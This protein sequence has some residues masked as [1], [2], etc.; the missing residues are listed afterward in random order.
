[1]AATEK[2]K[3]WALKASRFLRA[4]LKRAGLTYQHLADRLTEHGLPETEGS[5]AAKI[6]RG[7]FPVAFWLACLAVL[8][9]GATT[10]EDL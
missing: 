6:Q 4:E 3:E 9:L 1:M 5:V 2:E 7:S 8:E 10:L